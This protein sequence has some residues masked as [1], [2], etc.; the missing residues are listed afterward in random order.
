MFTGISW[1]S[2]LM[3][4]VA[5]SA[6]YYFY[7]AVRYYSSDLTAWISKKSSRK[8][9]YTTVTR[10]P[11]PTEPLPSKIISD[12]YETSESAESDY[13]ELEYLIGSIQKTISDAAARSMK[14]NELKG[15]LGLVLQEHP[16]LKNDGMRPAINELVASECAKQNIP[17]SESEADRL[18]ENQI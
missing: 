2:Y 13:D 9:A 16:S 18:W 5:S 11:V 12:N 8:T 17:I 7:V 14:P 3:L 6:I 1:Q 10:S 15:A 4:V